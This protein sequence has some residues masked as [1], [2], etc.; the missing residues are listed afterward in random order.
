MHRGWGDRITASRHGF[1]TEN[2]S[3][4]T[5]SVRWTGNTADSILTTQKTMFWTRAHWY[6]TATREIN[7][8]PT[9]A[10]TTVLIR[11]VLNINNNLYYSTKTNIHL[12]MISKYEYNRMAVNRH[13]T[14]WTS[15]ALQIA[16]IGDGQSPL[17]V[18]RILRCLMNM[19]TCILADYKC[20]KLYI[21]VRNK[22][23]A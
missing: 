17:F 3:T 6:F 4:T 14:T 10:T 8:P 7:E 18:F 22:T 20:D 15:S 9:T 11:D 12:F 1:T 23:D 13:K 5:R 21:S 19:N 16:N 2:K